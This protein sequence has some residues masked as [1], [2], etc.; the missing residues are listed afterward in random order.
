MQGLPLHGGVLVSREVND[1]PLAVASDGTVFVNV[2]HV[3]GM[4]EPGELLELALEEEGEV[5]IGVALE[6]AEV[7][8]VLRRLDDGAA[9]AVAN[10]L[11][12]R[13]WKGADR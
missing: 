8:E 13:K 9:D 7:E 1:A 3:G 5:F 10:V 2:T 12:A 6:P 11:G 4:K